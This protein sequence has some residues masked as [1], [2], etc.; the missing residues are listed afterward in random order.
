[1]QLFKINDAPPYEDLIKHFLNNE[2]I[3]IEI[4]ELSIEDKAYIS[5][6]LRTL[7]EYIGKEEIYNYL[8]YS[9]IELLENAKKA[10]IKRIFFEEHNLDITDS[11]D[12]E[13]G[14]KKFKDELFKNENYFIEQ[15]KKRIIL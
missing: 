3:I 9:F 11:T 2:E 4:Y 15:I 10:N 8:Q 12:Y 14:M 7:L 6:F 5:E 13:Q 1:M